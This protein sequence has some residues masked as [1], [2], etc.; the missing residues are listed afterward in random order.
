MANENPIYEYKLFYENEEI[1]LADLFL[2][3]VLVESEGHFIYGKGIA[4][5]VFIEKIVLE[6]GTY[7]VDGNEITPPIIA[8]GFHCDV[9]SEIELVFES[10]I[11][12][13]NPKHK[14]MWE[15]KN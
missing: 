6:Y 2:K 10:E 12:P 13:K 9:V 7:D 15:Y 5:V 3:E 4:S 8:D 1:A 14:F 11:F